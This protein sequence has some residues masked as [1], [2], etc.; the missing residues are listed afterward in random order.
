MWPGR[1]SGTGSISTG[2]KL[3]VPCFPMC[4]TEFSCPFAC[5]NLRKLVVQGH[6]TLVYVVYLTGAVRSSR[7][8]FSKKYYCLMLLLVIA[9]A[10]EG[11]RASPLCKES[12]GCL[13][14]IDATN[15]CRWILCPSLL[16]HYPPTTW[17][18]VY[19]RPKKS[20]YHGNHYLV[21]LQWIVVHVWALWT[22]I[23]TSISSA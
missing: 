6:P 17:P 9:A 21:P 14:E 1:K 7:V 2:K 11:T 22:T 4:D 13:Q 5:N 10:L 15:I 8:A 20:W 3:S 23:N 12:S 19:N 16:D 18:L